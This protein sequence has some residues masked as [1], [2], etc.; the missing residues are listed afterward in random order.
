LYHAK[1]TKRASCGISTEYTDS[2]PHRVVVSRLTWAVRRARDQ[3][4]D[5]KAC[6]GRKRQ[7]TVHL[8]KNSLEKSNAEAKYAFDS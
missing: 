1:A 6:S 7:L 4:A 2:S 3:L 8:Y 5:K